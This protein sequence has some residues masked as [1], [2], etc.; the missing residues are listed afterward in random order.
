MRLDEIFTRFDFV[1]IITASDR[2]WRVTQVAGARIP[3]C[4]N[5]FNGNGLKGHHWIF[6]FRGGL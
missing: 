5:G 6:S 3:V 2:L 1:E 4:L